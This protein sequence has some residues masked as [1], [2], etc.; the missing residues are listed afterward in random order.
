MNHQ[1][2]PAIIADNFSDL[3]QKINKVKDYVDWIQLD[4]MD[5]RFVQRI[6]WYNPQ[7]LKDLNPEIMQQVN[8]EAHLMVYKPERVIEP[9]LKSGVKRIYIHYESTHRKAELIEQIKRAGIEVGFALDIVTPY[10]FIESFIPNLDAVLIMTVRPGK[11]GQ[12][13]REE[14]LSKVRNLHKKYPNLPIGVD[15]GVNPDTAKQILEAG[16]TRLCSG[17]YVLESADTQQAIET[18]KNIK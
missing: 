6:T 5:G 7:E 4:V 2:I 15:G 3:Q 18:L 14:T 1:V 12:K 11:S 17:S 16:A 8:F 9:W 10:T 13:F